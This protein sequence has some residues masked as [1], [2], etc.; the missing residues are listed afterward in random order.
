[1]RRISS[2]PTGVNPTHPRDPLRSDP[3]TTGGDALAGPEVDFSSPLP[4]LD[5]IS[6]R[7]FDPANYKV[8]RTSTVPTRQPLKIAPARSK[9]CELK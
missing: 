3:G 9:A 2:G 4:L 8:H 1:M 7:L 5:A 6:A